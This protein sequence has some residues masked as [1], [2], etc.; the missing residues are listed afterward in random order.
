MLSE[1]N[2]LVN[3]FT[4][5]IFTISVIFLWLT[6][7]NEKLRNK[8]DIFTKAVAE[9][10]NLRVKLNEYDERIRKT[11]NKKERDFLW[12]DRDTL[13]FNFFEYVSILIL[14]NSVNEKQFRA[15]FRRFLANVFKIFYDSKGLLKKGYIEELDYPYLLKIFKKWDMNNKNSSK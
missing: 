4:A 9:E 1:I 3:I 13:L 14:S 2:L 10:Q 7:R 6:L 8:N 15:Y 11:K 5:L 12:N